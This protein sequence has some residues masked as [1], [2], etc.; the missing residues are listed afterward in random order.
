MKTNMLGMTTLIKPW[1]VSTAIFVAPY[2]LFGYIVALQGLDFAAAYSAFVVVF[3]YIATG[4]MLGFKPHA[5]KA[6]GVAL[7]NI[8]AYL[9]LC[10]WFDPI[11]LGGAWVIL[12]VTLITFI[13]VFY[14]SVLVKMQKAFE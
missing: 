12:N 6:A 8:A 3:S 9:A 7:N 10:N 5:V 1:G 2:V 13:T 14:G 4:V 11:V